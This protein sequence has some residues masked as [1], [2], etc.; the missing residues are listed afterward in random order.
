MRWSSVCN[1]S[2]MQCLVRDNASHLSRDLMHVIY[3][4]IIYS[5]QRCNCAVDITTCRWLTRVQRRVTV[6]GERSIDNLMDARYIVHQFICH[7]IYCT[8]VNTCCKLKTRV[9]FM[10]GFVQLKNSL[11]HTM[12]KKP[13]NLVAARTSHCVYIWSL[14]SWINGRTLRL[15]GQKCVHCLS[16]MSSLTMCCVEMCSCCS[17][18]QKTKNSTAVGR[19]AYL[20]KA[21]MLRLTSSNQLYICVMWGK[22]FGK[23]FYKLA[24][25]IYI[26]RLIVWVELCVYEHICIIHHHHMGPHTTHI[27]LWCQ[28]ADAIHFVCIYDVAIWWGFVWCVLSRRRIAFQNRANT[29]LAA[30]SVRIF[31]LRSSRCRRVAVCFVYVTHTHTLSGSH[32]LGWFNLSAAL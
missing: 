22:L 18:I 4:F 9:I 32:T 30:I 7:C 5:L 1:Y 10:F 29:Y 14:R 31:K 26:Y 13:F 20:G 6:V 23:S 16:N 21:A 25:N 12:S 2:I 3:C 28:R 15:C 11:G 17:N 27:T 8:L 19:H 24:S